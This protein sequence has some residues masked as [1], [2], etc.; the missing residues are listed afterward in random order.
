MNNSLTTNKNSGRMRFRFSSLAFIM[1]G[2]YLAI[3][4]LCYI[5]FIPVALASLSL[6]GFVLLS[7]ATLMVYKT[8]K[9]SGNSWWLILFITL[10]AFSSIYSVDRGVSLTAT[11]E[12]LKLFLFAFMMYNIID[13]KERIEKVLM[14][15]SVATSLLILYL[16]YTGDL[17]VEEER[18]GQ[19]L[20]GN[21]NLLAGLLM[22]GAFSS[23]YFVSFSKKKFNKVLFTASF[24][25]QLFALSLTGSRKFFVLPL[26][27]FCVMLVMNTG[28][29]GKR[30]IFSKSILAI[31]IFIGIFWLLFN[32]EF[33]YNAIGYRM[34]GLFNLF[35]GEGEADAS[36]IAR[37]ELLQQALEYWKNSPIIGNGI[38]SFKTMSS[39]GV[40]AH[41]NYGELLCD[42]GIV[43][44]IAYYSY[45]IYLLSRLFKVKLKSS[46]K[47]YWIIVIV[48]IA[49][50]D[51]G[52]VSYN[53]FYVHMM[54]VLA[55]LSVKNPEFLMTN[56][57]YSGR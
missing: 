6:Y 27:L 22:F 42:M 20:T 52:A 51:I 47:W 12:M 57:G 45:F 32:V 1:L 40:Y 17:F 46:V 2:M 33:F 8:P 21:A 44:T 10:C 41:N 16:M 29:S 48:C 37:Q 24:V 53:M 25:L 15:N 50:F 11:F 54:L 31:V 4:V 3:T 35:G 38:D 13:C 23:V 7:V 26:V 19:T 5:E 9:I 34:E 36:A 14:V 43:G 56:S 18:L 30:H 49:I 39:Y 28:K 55:A